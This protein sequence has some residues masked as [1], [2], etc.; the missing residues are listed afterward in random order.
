MIYSLLYINC[1]RLPGCDLAIKNL[2]TG[3][4]I[5]SP[6]RIPRILGEPIPKLKSFLP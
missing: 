1:Q 3:A 6:Y 5:H 2:F 4:K